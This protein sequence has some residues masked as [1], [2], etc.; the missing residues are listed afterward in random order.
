[1]SPG[2]PAR[3]AGVFDVFRKAAGNGYIGAA[4]GSGFLVAKSL[5]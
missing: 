4:G 3:S 2:V 5:A 1:M